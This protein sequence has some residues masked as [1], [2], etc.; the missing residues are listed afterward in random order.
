MREFADGRDCARRGRARRAGALSVGIDP[1]ARRAGAARHHGARRIRRRG[2]RRD[3]QRNHPRRDR[4][5]RRGGRA[6]GRLAQRAV[7]GSHPARGQRR[8]K[9]RISAA[10]RARREAWRLGADRTGIGLR[11]RRHAHAR[12]ARRGPLADSRRQTVHYAGID[13]RH[14]RHHGVD[15]SVAGHQRHLGVHRRSRN[16]RS[17]CRQAG[18]EARRSRVRYR[19]ASLR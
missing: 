10:A 18:K 9:A 13:S 2:V 16:A 4:A 17:R 11:C 7:L 15:R 14:L 8:S 5:R 19:R 1:E 3:Q 12:H 6:A